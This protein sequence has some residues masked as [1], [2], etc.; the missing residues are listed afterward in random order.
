MCDAGTSLGLQAATTA[1]NSV[2]SFVSASGQKTA[3]SAKAGIADVN[4]RLADM[5]SDSVRLRGAREEQQVRMRTTQLKSAQKVSMAANGID[6]GSQSAVN[7]LTSTDVMG[8]IDANTAA[9]NAL[10]E[11][12]GYKTQATGHRSEAALTRAQA[13]GVNPF[14][15]ASGTLLTGASSIAMNRYMMQKEGMIGKDSM[16]YSKGQAEKITWNSPRIGGY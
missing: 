5:Q 1:M 4:A 16:W 13:K 15:E 2:G 6:L 7:V 9:A 3:L 8:E 12:W 14:S 11:A 10:R